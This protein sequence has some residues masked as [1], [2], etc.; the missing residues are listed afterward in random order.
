MSKKELIP[1]LIGSAVIVIIIFIAVFSSVCT[2]SSN[3]DKGDVTEG[4]I[5]TTSA[6]TN[7]GSALETNETESIPPS[8]A[9]SVQSDED[10][11]GTMENRAPE[12]YYDI[13][14]VGIGD[15]VGGMKIK[16]LK[17]SGEAVDSGNLEFLV[18]LEGEFEATGTFAADEMMDEC[19]FYNND[20]Y[21]SDFLPFSSL[22]A[23]I[24]KGK[25][26]KLK[27]RFYILNEDELHNEIGKLHET[28]E[29]GQPVNLKVIFSE[30]SFCIYGYNFEHWVK[31]KKLIEVY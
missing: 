28:Y 8:S 24:E 31:F 18:T 7:S 5:Q 16:E 26:N 19:L 2:K 3:S 1:F 25:N 11:T 10:E 30:Y 22:E 6:S 4:G 9:V 13:N 20:T 29:K 27:L 21:I 17:N 14:K 23:D 12:Y 15:L